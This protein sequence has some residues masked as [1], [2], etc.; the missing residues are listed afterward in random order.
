MG[1]QTRLALLVYSGMLCVYLS[2]FSCVFIAKTMAA[3]S[4]GARGGNGM[5]NSVLEFE[6]QFKIGLK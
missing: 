2:F 3:A 4:I 6:F 5:T 1:P